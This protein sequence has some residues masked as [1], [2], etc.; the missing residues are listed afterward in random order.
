VE[1]ILISIDYR[2]P[3]WIGV[4]FLFGLGARW[5]RLPP[6]VGFLVAGFVLNAFGAESDRFLSEVADLG[7]TLLLFTI[8]LKFRIGVLAR[9]EIWATTSIH[10]AATTAVAAALA[11]GLGGLG[12]ALFP[13][14]DIA[15]VSIVAFALSFSS[16]V[17]AVKTLED[18]GSMASRYG[19]IAVG[20]LIMQDIAAVAFLA[21]S[22]GKLPSVWALGLLLLVPGRYLI[23]YL[24]AGSG[25]KELLTVFGFAAALGGAALFE[26]VGLKGDFGA[27]VIGLLLASHPRADELSKTLMGFKD[28]FLVCFFLAIGLTGLPT[29]ETLVAAL[30][31]LPLLPFKAALFYWLLARFR[32]RAR[33]STLSASL[34]CNYSEFGLIVAATA[35]GAGWLHPD[36]LVV[37]AVTVSASFAVS[38][39]LNVA[40]DALYARY[41]GFLKRFEVAERLPGD[42]DIS[43]GGNRVLVF[44]MGRIGRA[45]Y[46]EMRESLGDHILGIDLD[47]TEVER[48]RA[49]GRRIVNGD[50]TNPE[51]W[52]RIK[53]DHG[54]VEM[55]LLAM[56]HHRANVIAAGRLRS[57][58]YAGP[59]VAT[60]LFPDQ[61]ESLRERGVDEVF[62]IYAEAGVGAASKVWAALENAGRKKG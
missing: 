57:R 10:M 61:E 41:R 22:A 2:D 52:S 24:L 30:L 55:I 9:R 23:G 21:A 56:P 27:L 53:G 38:A 54:S 62:N 20:I 7:V 42:D 11:L 12:L 50:A 37:M 49:A 43:L 25:H 26:V 36:W 31:L 33:G 32:L 39:P 28:V 60:A 1:P 34:L 8:G 3:A 58:G 48:S 15:G 5:L 29:A 46:D 19:Q 51:F 40:A 17:F 47:E 13:G 14:L 16:T 45:A 6:M 4:A 18:R 59:I 35:A 44:G